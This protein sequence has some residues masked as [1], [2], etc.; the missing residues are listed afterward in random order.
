M[1]ISFTE[2]ERAL[3]VALAAALDAEGRAQIVGLPGDLATEPPLED[4]WLFRFAD[5]LELLVAA[6]YQA[7]LPDGP[8][9]AACAGPEQPGGFRLVTSAP[10][11]EAG[12]N[13]MVEHLM[14]FVADRDAG[15]PAAV[16]A[17]ITDLSAVLGGSAATTL[18]SG[19]E[20]AGDLSLAVKGQAQALAVVADA[21][22]SHLHKVEPRRPLRVLLLGPSGTG[23]TETHQALVRALSTAAPEGRRWQGTVVQGNQLSEA[24]AVADLLGSPAGYVGHG[25]GSGLTQALASNPWSVVLFDEWTKAHKDVQTVLMGAMDSGFLQLRQPVGGRWQ[26]DCRR[27]IFLFTSNLGAAQITDPGGQAPLA[28]PALEEHARQV[29][30]AH[31]MPEWIAGRH[32]R[33]AVYRPL[34][35]VALAE[36]ATLQ[37]AHVA[38]EFGLELAWVEPEVVSRLLTEA[39]T[40]ATGARGLHAAA[41]RLAAPA[42]A[43][44]R[45]AQPPAP[46]DP[47][48]ARTDQ[49]VLTGPPVR[50]VPFRSWIAPASSDVTSTEPD[51]DEEGLP[52]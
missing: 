20:L 17:Q 3:A 4:A 39:D 25:N 43:A 24:H 5:Q 35:T 13:A 23:K 2:D 15:H 19:A 36:I 27:A 33:I 22:A 50:C 18:P 37:L 46:A 34:S 6:C 1:P 26:L 11:T 7:T 10:A 12:L 44:H 21:V 48:Q 14:A 30:I 9:A 49:V 45:A 41:E 38:A 28:G 51:V 31:G 16:P 29:L 52:G 40:T 32:G 42:L 47:G 8:L